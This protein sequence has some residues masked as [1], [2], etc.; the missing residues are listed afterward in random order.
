M[1]GRYKGTNPPVTKDRIVVF[2]KEFPELVDNFIEAHK[3]LSLISKRKSISCNYPFRIYKNGR[4]QIIKFIK[5][6][7]IHY[8]CKSV[9]VFS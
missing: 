9:A 6:F 1:S 8:C 3:K 7:L 4:S 2:Y 5:A